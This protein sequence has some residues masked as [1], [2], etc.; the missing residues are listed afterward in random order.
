[1]QPNLEWGQ[2][3]DVFAL[4][5]VTSPPGS[6]SHWITRPVGV[7]YR[8]PLGGWRGTVCGQNIAGASRYFQGLD[9][10]MEWVEQQIRDA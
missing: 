2:H 8:S 4:G 5:E 3:G 10:A 1:M 7:A 9:H 6:Q